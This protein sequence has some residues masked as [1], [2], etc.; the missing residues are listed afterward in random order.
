MSGGARSKV[1]DLIRELKRKNRQPSIFDSW[2]RGEVRG[3]GEDD[4]LKAEK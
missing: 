3:G 2:S 1:N 4:G